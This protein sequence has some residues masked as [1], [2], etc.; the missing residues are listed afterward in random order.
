MNLLLPDNYYCSLWKL[1]SVFLLR[2]IYQWLVSYQ[3]PKY[4][5]C[6]NTLSGAEFHLKN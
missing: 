2:C 3:I 5:I 4:Q 1:E 6:H